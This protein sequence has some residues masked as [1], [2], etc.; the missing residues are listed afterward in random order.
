MN[1]TPKQL[2]EALNVD[3]DHRHLS[4]PQEGN[5]FCRWW[6]ECQFRCSLCL[7]RMAVE[8]EDIALAFTQ[9]MPWRI[10]RYNLHLS[11][12]A[13]GY[14]FLGEWWKQAYLMTLRWVNDQQ[15]REWMREH[16]AKSLGRGREVAQL[17]ETT[18]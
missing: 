13:H 14:D 1:L 5:P 4:H 11:P 2:R 15:D 10:E 9:Q 12:L 8:G 3:H 17:A 16:L 6:Q 18:N 7:S